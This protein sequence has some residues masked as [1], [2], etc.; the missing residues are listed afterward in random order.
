[1]ENHIFPWKREII[2][3][4]SVFLWSGSVDVQMVPGLVDW[5]TKKGRKK[6]LSH[7]LFFGSWIGMSWTRAASLA[8][9]NLVPQVYQLLYYCHVLPS[10]NKVALLL[11]FTMGIETLVK[12]VEHVIKPTDK[13]RYGWTLPRKLNSWK[14]MGHQQAWQ[15][16]ER[17]VNGCRWRNLAKVYFSFLREW[18][19]G[20]V[21]PQGPIIWSG[22]GGGG[23]VIF[24]HQL[25]LILATE[26]EAQLTGL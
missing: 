10:L 3:L 7:W 23:E 16:N 20:K 14:K 19:G 24:L 22:G 18:C 26:K 6:L 25:V 9:H 17:V 4:R 21:Y 5:P 1:M 15:L 13:V 2:I 12:Y 11:P 8:E